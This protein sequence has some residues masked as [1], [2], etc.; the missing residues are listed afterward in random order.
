MVG[1]A[2]L[3][4]GAKNN[5]SATTNATGM[6]RPFRTMSVAAG[7]GQVRGAAGRRGSV[8]RRLRR[9]GRGWSGK[10]EG[11]DP[12]HHGTEPHGE[13]RRGVGGRHA[14]VGV[15]GDPDRPGGGGVGDA[16][17]HRQQGEDQQG[18]PALQQRSG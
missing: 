10:A 3:A 6:K 17:S 12:D 18:L 7:G 15:E 13:E 2:A 11:D 9:G 14:E 4:G 5:S 16:V 8:V 1:S